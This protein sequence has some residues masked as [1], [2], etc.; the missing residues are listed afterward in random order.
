MSQQ[1]PHHRFHGEQD[2]EEVEPQL[3]HGESELEIAI[4]EAAGQPVRL[5]PHLCGQGA[6]EL[7]V[8][9]A[10]HV[11]DA[12]DDEVVHVELGE[13]HE[14]GSVAGRPADEAVRNGTQDG[15]G[16]HLFF[17]VALVLDRV[18]EVEQPVLLELDQV[19]HE[20][21]RVVV[22][23]S[24]VNGSPDAGRLEHGKG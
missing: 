15:Y 20:S 16:T 6:Q 4:D 14:K 2:A 23:A 18:G 5:L 7:E 9:D 24:L 8:D 11:P 13:H 10:D 22:R 3:V 19:G 1:P 21:L 17:G 12:V